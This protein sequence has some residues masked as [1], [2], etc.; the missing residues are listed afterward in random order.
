MQEQVNEILKTGTTSVSTEDTPKLMFHIA[1]RLVDTIKESKKLTPTQSKKLANFL[2]TQD[3]EM[4]DLYCLVLFDVLQE[5]ELK[6]LKAVLTPFLL[7][8]E[9][10]IEQLIYR[11]EVALMD[12]VMDQYKETIS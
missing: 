5:R 9:G 8:T 11:D 4:V 6:R 2:H 12:K 1:K 7:H 3:P 10:V